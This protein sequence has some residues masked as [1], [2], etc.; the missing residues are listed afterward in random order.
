MRMGIWHYAA[1]SATDNVFTYL[2]VFYR[3]ECPAFYKVFNSLKSI[4]FYYVLMLY[5]VKH[6]GLKEYR[7]MWAWIPEIWHNVT[8]SAI[9]IFFLQIYIYSIE[10]SL[11]FDRMFNLLNSI[12]YFSCYA[13]S[14]TRMPLWIPRQVNPI[15]GIWHHPT[16]SATDI[17]LIKYLYFVN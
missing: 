16:T 3:L 15:I 13:T 11:A 9:D 12:K 8:I 2:Y 17:F 1:T 7:D 6:R 10:W 14:N 4:N 5:F